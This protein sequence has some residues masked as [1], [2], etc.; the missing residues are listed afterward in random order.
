MTRRRSDEGPP[1]RPP[2]TLPWHAV[3]AYQHPAPKERESTPQPVALKVQVAPIPESIK[4]LK[5]W[6][7]WRYSQDKGKWSKPPFMQNGSHAS[8]NDPGTWTTFENAI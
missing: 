4:A 6:A 7:F 1:E 2:R 5:R 8:S 3:H